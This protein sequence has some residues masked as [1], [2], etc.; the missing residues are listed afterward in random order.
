MHESDLSNP[1]RPF[2]NCKVWAELILAEFFNQGDIEKKEN[3]PI[4]FLCDRDQVDIPNSQ[5]GFI[6]GIILPGFRLIG[7]M[8]PKL[9]FF[10][11]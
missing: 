3:L 5:I 2:K 11:E 7:E 9:N 6:N 1:T 4:S 10:H 8:I